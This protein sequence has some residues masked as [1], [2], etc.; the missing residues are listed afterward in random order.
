[1]SRGGEKKGWA[2]GFRGFVPQGQQSKSHKK[3]WLPSQSLT[4][5]TF[6]KTFSAFWAQ[7]AWN[8]QSIKWMK[9]SKAADA[10]FSISRRVPVNRSVG[11]QMCGSPITSVCLMI[12]TWEWLNT[13]KIYNVPVSLGSLWSHL[14]RAGCNWLG[15]SSQSSCMA[16]DL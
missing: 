2:G 7:L 1:M 13:C 8:D 6:L 5:R 16:P 14:L 11:W 4:P 9:L 10:L 3:C 15:I 12:R